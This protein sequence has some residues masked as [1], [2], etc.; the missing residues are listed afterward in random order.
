MPIVT[1]KIG[2]EK[3][4]RNP[5][6]LETIRETV[7]NMH[8]VVVH[9]YMFIKLY[10]LQEEPPPFAFD[11]IFVRDVMKVLAW[12]SGGYQPNYQRMTAVTRARFRM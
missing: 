11:W 3:I 4:I 10:Y 6:S 8:K 2:I 1:R 7:V 9:T 12:K 5:D